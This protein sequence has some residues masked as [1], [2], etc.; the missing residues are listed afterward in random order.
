MDLLHSRLFRLQL[1]SGGHLLGKNCSLGFPIVLPALVVVFLN[2]LVSWAP[3]EPAREIMARFV[4]R[5]LILQTHMRSHPVGLDVWFFVGPF[6]YFH[7]SCVRTAKALVAYVISTIISWAG[8]NV[9][10]LYRFL[11][12]ALSYTF[13]QI[14]HQCLVPQFHYLGSIIRQG[15]VTEVKTDC[16]RVIDCVSFS[17][18]NI[19]I[20][21]A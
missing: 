3:N 17:L 21:S 1:F 13:N 6:V 19:M 7:T 4:L 14:F 15:I 20:L 18:F 10:R 16:M 9:F 5:K 12:I 11:I 2:G 8:S